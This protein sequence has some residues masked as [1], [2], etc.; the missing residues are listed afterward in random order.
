MDDK[1][2]FIFQ[3]IKDGLPI[4]LGY[5]SV[6]FAFGIFAVNQGLS[7]IEAL[8]ISMTN[9]T[10]AGQLAAVPI[11]AGK[12]SILELA[13]CQLIIN[14][15]YA[16]MS[17]ILSQ[18]LDENVS[19]WDKLWI[20]FANT[21]EIFAISTHQEG[22]ISKE[23]QAGLILT[24]WIG[25]SLGTLLGGLAGDILP[26]ILTKSL[27]VAIYGMFLAIIIPNG[28]KEKPMA[29]CILI[30]VAFAVLFRFTPVLKQISSGFTIIICAI[31]SSII[32]AMIAPIRREG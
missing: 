25:W 10:S 22:S 2:V 14:L 18:K 3:G 17:I 5:L 15:R 32:L 16:L 11:I 1:K 30:S 24:P 20:G 26:T 9:L 7:V 6:S 4:C 28:K 29:I 21:D 23:Y 27:A 31:I 19:F 13:S 12:K 8:L